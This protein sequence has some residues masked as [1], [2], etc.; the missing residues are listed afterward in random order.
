MNEESDSSAKKRTRNVFTQSEDEQ[1]R[2]LIEQYG[3]GDWKRIA[4]GVPGRSTRQCRERWISYL[5][6]H[7]VNGSWSE[8]EDKLLLEKLQEI[9]PQWKKLELYFPERSSINIKN[10]WRQI[11]KMSI[12]SPKQRH[13]SL[14][15]HL[16]TFDRLFSALVSEGENNFGSES[17]LHFFSF[18]IY[19]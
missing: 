18:D 2:R 19:L 7:I 3:D 1:I 16:V 13:N 9:G 8:A 4:E 17:T 15:D 10:H 14:T 11:Q 12:L 6:P 5:A